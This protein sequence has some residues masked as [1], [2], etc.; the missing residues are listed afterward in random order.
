MSTQRTRP[1][2]TEAV[3]ET[4]RRRSRVRRLVAS[5]GALAGVALLVAAAREATRSR[6]KAGGYALA[7]GALLGLWFRRRSTDGPSA[8]DPEAGG[9]EV[10]AEA[11]AHREQSK[12]LHQ[13]ETNPR[14]VSGEPD[15][16]TETDPDEGDV[17]FTTKQDEGAEPKPHLDDGSA[18]DPRHPDG[19]DPT[20]DGDH[21]TVNLSESAMADEPSEATGPTPEQAYPAREGT[22]P[23]PTSPEAPEREAEGAATNPGPVSDSDAADGGAAETEDAEPEE[24]AEGG[25]DGSDDGADRSQRDESDG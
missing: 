18:E 14:G 17:R 9:P 24:R 23:E 13:S 12:V 19:E 3:R 20:T 16:E 21:V 11:R 7:G 4:E 25:E 15:V 22:D 2:D 5:V 6:R 10:S 8:P 1:D